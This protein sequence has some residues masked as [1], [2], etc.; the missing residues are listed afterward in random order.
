MTGRLDQVTYIGGTRCT[1]EQG[2]ITNL[3][4]QAD[5]SAI[6]GEVGVNNSFLTTGATKLFWRIPIFVFS[7]HH[8]N[9]I[10]IRPTIPLVHFRSVWLPGRLSVCL[11]GRVA[12]SGWLGSQLTDFLTSFLAGNQL[13]EL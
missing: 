8:C 9:R 4:R 7:N 1:M 13:Y 2:T 6:V 12:G 5:D 3:F 11:A 10:F